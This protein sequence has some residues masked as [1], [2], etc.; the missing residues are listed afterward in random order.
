[1]SVGYLFFP[2]WQCD[3]LDIYLSDM[4]SNGYRLI[5]TSF[6]GFMHFRK[7][8][9]KKVRYFSTYTCVK[10]H[11]MNGI[12]DVLRSIYKANPIPTA[13]GTRNVHRVTDIEADF[14]ELEEIRK[15]AMPRI[16]GERLFL[17]LVPLIG[18]LLF[19]IRIRLTLLTWIFSI[20][21]MLALTYYTTG[22]L[23]VLIRHADKGR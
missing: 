16:I 23:S 14:S 4:E 2:V 6:L 13:V 20:L 3:K 8:A 21:I 10:E 12:E 19:C 18:I 15:K 7:S 9:P 11:S 17:S 1:M 22:M 5:G